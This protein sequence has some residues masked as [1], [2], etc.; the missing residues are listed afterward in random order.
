MTDTCDHVF[1]GYVHRMDRIMRDSGYMRMQQPGGPGYYLIK[2]YGGRGQPFHSDR[3]QYDVR[4][5][6]R[7]P[8]NGNSS[9]VLVKAVDNGKVYEQPIFPGQVRA[10]VTKT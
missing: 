3:R 7:I 5:C 4:V 8:R 6:L 9:A 10:A 1:E 2:I